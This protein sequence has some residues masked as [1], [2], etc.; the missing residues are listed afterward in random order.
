MR[1][2]DVVYF[3]ESVAREL[4]VACAVKC[5]CEKRYGLSVELVQWPYDVPDAL[6]RYRPQVVVIPHGWSAYNWKECLLDW[7][8]A[9]YFDLAWE[10]LL[11]DGNRD[12]KTPRGDFACKHVIHH[13][14]GDAFVADLVSRGVPRA[15]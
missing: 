10:Q 8:T 2:I 5:L 9:I 11:Y 7:R 14:W 15:N 6:G 13:A 3:Y 1:N 12:A 4:D